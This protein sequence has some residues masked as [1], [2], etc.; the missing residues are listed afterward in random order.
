MASFRQSPN[1]FLAMLPGSDFELLRPH[2]RPI[3]LVLGDTLVEAGGRLLMIYF[4]HSG[5]ISKVV[6]LAGGEAIEVA[7]IGRE[8]VFGG[9]A[10]LY[11]MLSPTAGIVRFPGMA[12]TIDVAHFRAIA[13]HSEG[14]RAAMMQRQW[15]HIVEA[16]QSAA[17][18]ASHSIEARLSRRLLMA[19]DLS[20]SN[21]LP[22]TQEILAQMLGVQRNSISLI[23][24]ALQLLGLIRYSRGHLEIIDVEGLIAHS[25]ECYQSLTVQSVDLD[26]RAAPDPAAVPPR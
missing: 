8:G 19:R 11:G 1:D 22:L 16:E 6:H 13:E 9:S 18:N 21:K 17:C 2:L 4:P 12:S 10:A 26:P 24:N 5:I 14:L 23:A 25:C 7:M 3:E 15:H 20:G